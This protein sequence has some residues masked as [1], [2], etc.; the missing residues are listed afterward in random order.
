MQ[1]A[2]SEHLAAA[3]KLGFAGI[4]VKTPDELRKS[5][6]LII[7]G[8]ESTAISRLIQKNGL[9]D[10]IREFA[11]SKPVFG[12]CAGLILCGKNILGQ[13]NAEHKVVPLELMESTVSRNGFGRQVDSFEVNLDVEGVGADIPA[14]FIRA[15]YIEEVG[16][17]VKVLAKVE[18]PGIQGSKIVAAEYE[19][20][21]VAAFHPE[22]TEDL[23][24]M[25]Y[26]CSKI[27][28]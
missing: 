11:G 14:V 4:P 13:E 10:A 25:E 8:G 5:D 20:I 28:N 21:L 18:H 3:R 9:F 22:L 15:P 6:A 2:V 16:P 12:T 17:G 7:P 19:N 23:R 24:L 27:V 1:G 26:F